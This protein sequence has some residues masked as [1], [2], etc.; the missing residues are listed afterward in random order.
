MKAFF[1][2]YSGLTHAL[3]GFWVL[4]VGAYSSN[5]GGFRDLVNGDATAI[6]HSL[7]ANLAKV[8]SAALALGLS[9]WG[10]YRNGQKA[11]AG[12]AASAT[13]SKA[14]NSGIAGVLC[15]A[16]LMPLTLPATGCSES[17]TV[18]EINTVLTEAT[19]ILAVADPSATWVPQLKSAVASLETAE[20]TWQNGGAIQI[21]DDA[22][23]TVV[24]VTAAIP[25]TA[26]YSPLVDILVAGIEAVLAALP[27]STSTAT[28][29]TVALNPHI[30]R[31]VIKHH[32]LHSRVD[33]FKDAWNAAVKANPSLA[34][35]AL[36]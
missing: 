29:A 3:A 26:A 23:N 4:L 18:K 31:V 1:T 36:K 24:A 12:T 33:D 10:F 14:F 30:G 15:F 2:K 6:Y 13:T 9:L 17:S 7:P 32:F 11:T 28:T 22:L 25:L 20:T 5:A 34:A 16:L 19:N 35:A 8:V 27:T 21:V